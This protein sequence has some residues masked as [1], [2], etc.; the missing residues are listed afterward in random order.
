MCEGFECR[1]LGSGVDVETG[2]RYAPRGAARGPGTWLN[3]PVIPVCLSLAKARR[4]GPVVRGENRRNHGVNRLLA[5]AALM[6]FCATAG[7]ASL[8]PIG[9]IFTKVKTPGDFTAGE[10]TNPGAGAIT[11]EACA[12]SILGLVATGDWSVDAALR[13]AGAE[14]KTLKNVAI[15]HPV[16]SILGLYGKFCTTVSAQV[17][18]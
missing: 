3:C 10:T 2:A 11:G 7:C 14:G 16:F 9:F 1:F 6:V 15:D 4:P 12:I 8:G 13:A 17:A 18:G 5:C